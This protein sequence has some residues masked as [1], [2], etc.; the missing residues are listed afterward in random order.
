MPGSIS[1]EDVLPVW[2]QDI[3]LVF[4]LSEMLVT[5]RE[6][7]R[8]VALTGVRLGSHWGPFEGIRIAPFE[9]SIG[10]KFLSIE[11]DCVFLKEDG[12]PSVDALADIQNDVTLYLFQRLT[13]WSIVEK[14]KEGLS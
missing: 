3:N 11:A 12:T 13:S 1:L 5:A 6:Q 7:I 4:Q 2:G 10:N 8:D 14:S 9:G